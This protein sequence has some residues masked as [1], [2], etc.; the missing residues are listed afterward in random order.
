MD[1]DHFW[2]SESL[3]FLYAWFIATWRRMTTKILTV[4]QL[5]LLK[6]R[7]KSGIFFFFILSPRGKTKKKKK[8]SHHIRAMRIYITCIRSKIRHL[9]KHT[10]PNTKESWNTGGQGKTTTTII[11]FSSLMSIERLIQHEKESRKKRLQVQSTKM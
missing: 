10:H 2:S 7:M 11:V 4:G 5:F 1:S 6:P 3:S 8:K 9:E